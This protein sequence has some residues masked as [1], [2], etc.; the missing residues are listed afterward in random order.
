[1]WLHIFNL[2]ERSAVCRSLA[3]PHTNRIALFLCGV[4]SGVYLDTRNETRKVKTDWDLWVT[5]A[6]T[7]REICTSKLCTF[8]GCFPVFGLLNWTRVQRW[9]VYGKQDLKT[10][11]INRRNKLKICMF[12]CSWFK[13]SGPKNMYKLCCEVL[14]QFKISAFYLYI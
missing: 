2:S 6:L 10:H 5:D 7:I 11:C 1:M 9:I 12:N 4:W 14:L 8:I 13:Y 3:K